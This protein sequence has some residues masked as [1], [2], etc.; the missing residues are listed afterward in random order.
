MLVLTRKVGKAI[1]IGENIKVTILEANDYTVKIGVDA[2][3]DV[4]VHREEVFDR[5]ANGEKSQRGI[6]S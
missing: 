6:K 4:T 5:I 2:P 1:M 3:R